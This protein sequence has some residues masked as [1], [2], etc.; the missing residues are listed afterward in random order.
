MK[1]ER[2]RIAVAGLGKRGYSI[3]KVTLLPMADVDIVGVCDIYPDRVQAAADLVQEVR[4]VRPQETTDY[5]EMLH[6]GVDAV[7]VTAAWEAHI[8]IMVD[9]MKAGIY[10]GT[11]VA[12]AYSVED[13]WNLVRTSEATGVPCMFLENCCYGKRELMVL[14]MVKEGLFGRVMHCAGGYH[15]DLRDEITTGEEERH[16]RLRN[17]L[18]RNCE[19]YPSHELGPIAEILNI[20]HGNRMVTLTSTASASQGLHEYCVANRGP[21]DKLSQ[22]Q[23][24]QGDIVTT[25]IRCANG[26]T[27]TLTLDTSLPRYYNRGFTVHGTRAFYTEWNDTLFEDGKHAE[28]DFNSRPLW[29]NMAEYEKDWLHP[30]WQD[31]VPLGGHDG[32]DDLVYRA[33]VECAME[34][35]QP[36]MDVYDC[37]A[38]MAITPLSE[39]SIA[40]GGAPVAIPDFTCGRWANREDRP[41]HKYSLHKVIYE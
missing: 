8:P 14:R 1:K 39:A 28:Y 30:L 5:H 2:L 20:H 17:Y 6:E 32:M 24:N 11:E 16:Y 33:F 36:P 29:G 40:M 9:A 12:G 18:S 35:I 38:W 34:G 37:A 31:Y 26:E 27:I 3:I 13:C 41:E 7:I 10:V 4:G 25:V 15:H 21:E 22:A 23:F 19:N